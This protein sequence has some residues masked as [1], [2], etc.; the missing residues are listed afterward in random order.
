MSLILEALK[1]L[2]REKAQSGPRIV[3]TGEAP[4]PGDRR[5]ISPWRLGL[6]AFG[7]VALGAFVGGRLLR[8]SH[9]ASPASTG[10]AV[11][12][13]RSIDEG[14][15]KPA[16]ATELATPAQAAPAVHS[17]VV[18][19]AARATAPTPPAPQQAATPPR[20]QVDLPPPPAA[21]PSSPARKAS[22]S[23]R[24]KA[25]RELDDPALKTA[26]PRQEAAA[27]VEG[28]GVA[29]S[30][31]ADEP[32]LQAISEREGRAI[33][34]IN[35]RVMFEG[36]RMGELVVVAIRSN[37]VEVEVRGKRRVLRF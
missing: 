8:S 5:A 13:P 7:L 26:A 33:A 24:P 23:P 27:P 21:R 34:L 19:P 31:T 14:T 1:K 35:D 20:A 2:E 4:W 37:E 15:Q 12:E 22:P 28:P 18:P 32:R 25:P 10:G 3:T 29:P 6:A 36:D 16:P 11:D 9:E 30:P 17:T